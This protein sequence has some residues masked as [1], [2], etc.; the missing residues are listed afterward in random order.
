[1]I[2]KL[3]PAFMACIMSAAMV[4]CSDDDDN[5]NLPDIPVTPTLNIAYILN[6]GNM[7]SNIEGSLDVMN[8]DNN[9]VNL[10][11]FRRTNGQSLGNTPQAAVR[12]GSKIYIGV[13]E[14]NVIDVI[15]ATTY[16][17]EKQMSLA[18][19]TG[20]SP[21]SLVAKDG[22]VYISMYNGY[23]S[24]LDTLT[25]RIDATV[26]VGPN[27]EII[28]I[29]GNY[30]YVPNSDGMNWQEGYGTTASIINLNDFEA[31]PTTFTVP[32]NPAQFITNGS[33]LFLLCK[34]N[35]IDIDAQVY[36]VNDDNTTTPIAKATLMDIKDNNLYL[37]NAPWGATQFEYSVYNIATGASSNMIDDG[38]GVDSPAAIAVKPSTGDIFI[39]SY[40]LDNGYASYSTSGYIVRYDASGKRLTKQNVSIGPCAIFF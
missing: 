1:M 6:Q 30:L 25:Q 13:Y 2:K 19:E 27:P 16:K 7:G 28:A 29:K 8:L 9:T 36:R 11:V 40:N 38:D 24:R 5:D 15:N 23:V 12:Y 17:L 14:S 31:V 32:L 35:Y 21:R 20:Q 37:I 3:L 10:S 18:N 22:K 34:G 4:S 39:T 33:A 26:K